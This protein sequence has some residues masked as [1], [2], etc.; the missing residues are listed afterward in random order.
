MK[1]LFPRRGHRCIYVPV[2]EV[3]T[4]VLPYDRRPGRRL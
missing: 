1:I 3:K 2:R 4:E